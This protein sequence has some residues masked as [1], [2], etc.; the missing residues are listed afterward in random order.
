MAKAIFAIAI[1]GNDI[2]EYDT[3]SPHKK[4]KN[5]SDWIKIKMFCASR[6]EGIAKW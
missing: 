5:K 1:F 6:P 2:L 3:K 4:R